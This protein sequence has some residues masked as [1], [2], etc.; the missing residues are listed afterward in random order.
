MK[1]WPRRRWHIRRVLD[2]WAASADGR[3]LFEVHPGLTSTY[4]REGRLWDLHRAE[5][6][7]GRRYFATA[8][9]S[10][11]RMGFSPD[12]GWM[13]GM[14]YFGDRGRLWWLGDQ[15]SESRPLGQ[16]GS[17]LP[18][19]GDERART[20]GRSCG[21]RRTARC[22][23]GTSAQARS[24][25]ARLGCPAATPEDVVRAVSPDGR[26]LVTSRSSG[27]QLWRVGGEE[28]PP[29]RLSLRLDDSYVRYVNFTNDG[30]WLLAVDNSGAGTR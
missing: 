14:G 24:S 21:S 1:C 26:W 10:V 7:A 16:P 6:F 25:R 8:D 20:S 30:R 15:G 27:A 29:D 19:D 12:A 28:G 9:V 4:V 23:C 18:L 3:W 2:S 13:V 11:G 22:C 17:K 5:P